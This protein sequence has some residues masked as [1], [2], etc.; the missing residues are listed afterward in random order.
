MSN[1]EVMTDYLL[2]AIAGLKAAGVTR[3]VISPGSRST[4]LALLLHRDPEIECF[5]DVD[6][7]S[8][9]FF[10]LG[11]TKVDGEPTVLLCTSG[12]AAANYYPAICEAEAVNLPLI[13][14][15]A[16]R[17]P[18]LR[19]VGAPQA[20]DQQQLYGSHVKQMIEMTVPENQPNMLRYSFWQ[21]ANSVTEAKKHPKGPVHINFPLREP[22][23]PDLEKSSSFHQPFVYVEPIKQLAEEMIQQVLPQLQKKGVIIVGEALTLTQAQHLRLFAGKI[24]WPIIGDP[25]TNL[26]TCGIAAGTFIS[27]ADLLLPQIDETF[28]PEVVLRF[29]RLPVTKNVLLWLDRLPAS[30]TWLFV[31]ASGQWQ[32]QLHRAHY[33]IEAEID[34]FTDQW[35]HH[36]FQVDQGWITQW[37]R[38]QTVANQI[39]VDQ[40]LDHPF[41][42]SQSVRMLQQSLPTD[43]QI[44]LANSNAIRFFDRYGS[45]T[46]QPY[47]VYGNRGVNGIDGLISTVAGIAQAS[48]KP[49]YLLIGDLAMYHDMNG[50]QLLR[51]YQLPVTIILLNNDGGGIFSFLSQQTLAPEDFEPLF[52]T[53]LH[54]DFQKVAALYDADWSLAESVEAFQMQINASA[55]E[56]RFQILEVRGTQQEPVSLWTLSQKRFAEEWAK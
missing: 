34:C 52:G 37:Q 51:Q 18:E 23:L 40:F 16:D 33:L 44:L 39:I 19:G 15:T 10:A 7:R 25:L 54:L 50:L 13:V 9:A 56:P 12:T 43:A 1:Q 3:G 38:V 41:D 31:D 53:S 30:T 29:G 8:A 45:E 4:P 21:A 46:M 11:M 14:L 32:D 24:G 42:E 47:R 36:D 5:V 49:T 48:Q 28:Q 22:L 6:E 20:M 35:Q 26:A 27:Q 17:P 55:M 2:A